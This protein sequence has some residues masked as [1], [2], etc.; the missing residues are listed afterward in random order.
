MTVSPPYQT[1]LP[2][3]DKARAPEGTKAPD[4]LNELSPEQF[5]LWRR[6]PVTQLVFD[7][8][9]GDF[10]FTMERDTIDTWMAGRLTLNLELEARGYL[11]TMHLLQGLSLPMLKTFYGVETPLADPLKPPGR[12]GRGA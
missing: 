7:R 10:R 4:L 9:M 11:L 12:P 1:Q 6:H 5:A 2:A 3:P 8:Y